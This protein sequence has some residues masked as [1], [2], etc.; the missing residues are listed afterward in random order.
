MTNVVDKDANEDG[1]CCDDWGM[2]GGD[3]LKEKNGRR[4]RGELGLSRVIGGVVEWVEGY[5]G[6]G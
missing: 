6:G 3:N 1:A 2:V 5:G 4:V